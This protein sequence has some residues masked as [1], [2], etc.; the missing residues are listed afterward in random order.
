MSSRLSYLKQ[1][2]TIRSSQD[3]STYSL[4]RMEEDGSEYFL[5]F[6]DE[7]LNKINISDYPHQVGIAIPLKSGKDMPSA[8]ENEQILILERLIDNEYSNNNVGLFVGTIMGAGMKEFILYVSHFEESLKIFTK[9]K[10]LPHHHDIQYAVREDP[11]W[12]MYKTY[13]KS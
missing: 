7:L 10:G 12:E 5:R 8:D 13:T 9:L 6:K 3:S 1:K 4:F 2:V 11:D